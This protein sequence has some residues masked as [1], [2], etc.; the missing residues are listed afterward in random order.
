MSW[1]IVSFVLRSRSRR[2]VLASLATP[3]TPSILASE[4]HTSI[5]N[6]SR[7]LRE[8]RT[9]HLIESLTPDAHAGKLYIA[10]DQGKAVSL[11][12]RE[13][14]GRGGGES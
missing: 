9:R 14:S 12:V 4:L 11:K 3:K 13:I 10:T 6:I 7:T 5:P 1:E 8:L 2:V